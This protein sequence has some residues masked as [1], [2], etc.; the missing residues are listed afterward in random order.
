[1]P[2]L[3]GDRISPV[4]FEKFKES[5]SLKKPAKEEDTRVTAE[6]SS[7]GNF[8]DFLS[9]SKGKKSSTSSSIFSRL[10]ASSSSSSGSAKTAS[11]DNTLPVIYAVTTT[12][13]RLISLYLCKTKEDINQLKQAVVSNG[14]AFAVTE[15][16][17]L[18][19]ATSAKFLRRAL[20]QAQAKS[21]A[22]G[23]FADVGEEDDDEAHS[24]VKDSDASS[25]SA[26]LD[27]ANSDKVSE[28]G[29]GIQ[30]GTNLQAIVSHILTLVNQH[31]HTHGA[32]ATQVVLD[33]THARLE[34]KALSREKKPVLTK[35]TNLL[36]ALN[37]PTTE[38][39][40]ADANGTP[41]QESAAA[42]AAASSSSSSSSPS[43]SSTST[44]APA[45]PA[46]EGKKEAEKHEDASVSASSDDEGEE[47]AEREQQV[48]DDAAETGSKEKIDLHQTLTPAALAKL[49][50]DAARL[51]Q[52]QEAAQRGK[53]EHKEKEEDDDELLAQIRGAEEEAPDKGSTPSS[54]D[55]T[56]EKSEENSTSSSSSG[57]EGTA[58]A[59]SSTSAAKPDF[60]N[61][62]LKSGPG[63]FF[64]PM[65]FDDEENQ[66]KFI[67]AQVLEQQGTN[68]PSVRNRTTLLASFMQ[69]LLAVQATVNEGLEATDYLSLMDI[70]DNALR[71]LV[72]HITETT[73]ERDHGI[74]SEI[75]SLARAE[76][77]DDKAQ[78]YAGQT[79]AHSS[80]SYGSS[81]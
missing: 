48:V 26:A 42:A 66:L 78:T 74:D 72:K 77:K 54:G 76:I 52:Q 35:L 55:E 18:V 9:P 46:E 21:T 53:Q 45:T 81:D 30:R 8:F 37:L 59:S 10:N 23:S 68:G 3:L 67:K 12:A 47:E 44:S 17:I 41:S 75:I 61:T 6:S 25:S 50:E 80:L 28:I 19:G 65:F 70:L 5:V 57:D 20:M 7:P 64:G 36:N 29:G 60:S 79:I 39:T 27:R 73:L 43:S 15:S 69:T 2:M 33:N 62:W 31:L 16:P 11:E 40:M 32:S 49:Q 1:M 58:E 71:S 24:V 63:R 14:D 38:L 22:S 13:N 56:D 51:Q 34:D 4:V